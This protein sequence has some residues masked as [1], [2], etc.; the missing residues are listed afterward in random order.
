MGSDNSVPQR[1]VKAYPV[2]Q[3]LPLDKPVVLLQPNIPQAMVIKRR[4]FKNVENKNTKGGE[5]LFVYQNIG[6][7]L[8]TTP[9]ALQFDV[10]S[11]NDGFKVNSGGDT[12]IIPKSGKLSFDFN[13][14]WQS[15]AGVS[16]VLKY[17]LTINGSAV[18]GSLGETSAAIGQS[19]LTR[20]ESGVIC[21]VKE[22][23]RIQVV[24]QSSIEGIDTT[25]V[26]TTPDGTQS[27]SSL[28][29]Q[30]DSVNTKKEDRHGALDI[31]KKKRHRRDM[32]LLDGEDSN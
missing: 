32:D 20:A 4:A 10:A 28:R 12:F 31:K 9:Q 19:V 23:D 6:Q 3:S 2:S 24:A 14:T 8:I 17:W 15:A 22:G 18:P 1:A 26:V 7:P 5:S 11:C 30:L 13:I 29:L 21:N 25:Y 16:S 27:G